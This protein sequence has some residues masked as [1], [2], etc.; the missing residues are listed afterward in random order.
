MFTTGI[1]WHL[2]P[3][4]LLYFSLYFRQWFLPS[5]NEV[6]DEVM[7]LQVFVCPRCPR[8]GR[9][10][11]SGSRGLCVSVFGGVSLGQW[12][13]VH[14]TSETHPTGCPHPTLVQS[15]DK[16]PLHEHALPWT[17]THTH[18]QAHTCT[19]IH[20]ISWT[21]PGHPPPWTVNKWA[22]QILLE[23]FLVKNY[24]TLHFIGKGYLRWPLLEYAYFIK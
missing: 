14:T 6:W 3:L 22:V 15:L 18:T 24:F 1:F 4:C 13:G 9:M 5:V 20:N 16:H 19:W 17:H 2:T 10:S 11:A 23:C 7:F 21:H 8:E 12:G